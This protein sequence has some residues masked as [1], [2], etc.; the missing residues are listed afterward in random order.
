M[1]RLHGLKVGQVG[2]GISGDDAEGF[3]SRVLPAIGASL[4]SLQARFVVIDRNPKGL[5]AGKDGEAF[6]AAG[7]D[8][9]PYGRRPEIRKVAQRQSAFDALTD[10]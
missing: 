6:E 1:A 8:R 9:R 3:A 5:D 7:V 2:P 4:R 10:A